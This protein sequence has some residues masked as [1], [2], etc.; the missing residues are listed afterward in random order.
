MKWYSIGS[1][2]KETLG[3]IQHGRHVHNGEGVP[4]D[5]QEAVKSVPHGRRAGSRQGAI[6]LGSMYYKGKVRI[7]KR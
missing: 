7:T 4:E 2:S 6:Q 5:Y 1:P 3:S